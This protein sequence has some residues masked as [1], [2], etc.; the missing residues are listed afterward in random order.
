MVDAAGEIF[1]KRPLKSEFFDSINLVDM[2]VHIPCVDTFMAL[3][4]QWRRRPQ[5]HK[6]TQQVSGSADC[7][8]P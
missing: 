5:R 8:K 1:A 7:M 4:C 6:Q 3:T 2:A